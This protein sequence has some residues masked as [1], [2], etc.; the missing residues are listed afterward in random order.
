MKTVAM[1]TKSNQIE[2]NYS[3]THVQGYYNIIMIS[4]IKVYRMIEQINQLP[5]RP[6]KYA[7]PYLHGLYISTETGL[8][9]ETISPKS[10]KD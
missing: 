3:W 9:S 6:R 4:Q 7:D 8:Q 2:R 10:G 5:Y 1:V